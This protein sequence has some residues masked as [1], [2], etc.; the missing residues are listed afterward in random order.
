MAQQ[1]VEKRQR[2]LVRPVDVVDEEQQAGL[3]RKRAQEARRV[4]EQAQTLFA[5]RQRRVGTQRRPSFVSI[6]GANLAISAA[7]APSAVRSCSGLCRRVHSRKAS[8]NGM[9]GVVAS[10]S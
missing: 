1:V 2:A 4:V 10:Y 8:T 5:G 9:Y 7:V 3:G 6:S